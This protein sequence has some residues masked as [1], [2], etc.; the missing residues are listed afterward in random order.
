LTNPGQSQSSVRTTYRWSS[1][2]LEKIII[3][4]KQTWLS[5]VFW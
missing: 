1:R 4:I 2:L 5:T 3:T